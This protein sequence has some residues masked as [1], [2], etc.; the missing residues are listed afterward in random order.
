[1]AA[2]QCWLWLLVAVFPKG[3]VR[4]ADVVCQV[5]FAACAVYGP[6]EFLPLLVHVVRLDAVV[7]VVPQL[8]RWVRDPLLLSVGQALHLA[9]R[10]GNLWYVFI[11]VPR[12][13]FVADIAGRLQLSVVLVVHVVFLLLAVWLL[14]QLVLK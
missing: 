9:H 11:A 4:V 2:M 5:V 12:L 10:L 13:Q 14:C 8:R 6:Q 7:T 3:A 1:M